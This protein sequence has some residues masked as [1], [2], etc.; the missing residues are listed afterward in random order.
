MKNGI[1]L[2]LLLLS[3]DTFAGSSGI[4]VLRA[5]VPASY[6]VTFE[7]KGD[8][9]TPVIHSN[10]AKITPK[11]TMTLKNNHRLVSVVHP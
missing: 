1:G 10:R 2:F 11:V 3:L 7:K 9:L 6:S 8:S 5:R 4:L